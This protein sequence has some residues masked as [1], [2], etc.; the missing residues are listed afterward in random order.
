VSVPGELRSLDFGSVDHHRITAKIVAKKG[1]KRD[2][3]EQSAGRYTA[4]ADHSINKYIV[5]CISNWRARLAG[6]AS[7]SGC[8]SC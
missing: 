8:L 4:H 6:Q 1:I 7:S 5:S 2:K 3:T